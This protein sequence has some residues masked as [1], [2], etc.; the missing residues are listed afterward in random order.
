[1]DKDVPNTKVWVEFGQPG[2]ELLAVVSV[3]G[4]AWSFSRLSHQ[5]SLLESERLPVLAAAV[6]LVFG[7]WGQLWHALVETQWATA[8]AQ[9]R[10]WQRELPL[11][12]WPYLEPGTP[13]A[14]LH[15]TLSQA[16]A[17]WQDVGH[18]SLEL[19]LRS[20]LLA[21]T[22]TLLLSLVLGRIAIVCSL[23]FCAWA[24]LAALWHE[25]QG[26]V[27]ALWIGWA[28]VGLP[29]L[30]G[31]ML[32]LEAAAGA[33]AV[34]G[35]PAVGGVGTTAPEAKLATAMLSA[36]VL[37]LL[38]ALYLQPSVMALLGPIVAAIYLILQG[39]AF[40]AGV[41]LLLAFPGLRLILHQP[42]EDAYRRAVIPWLLIMLIIIAGSLYL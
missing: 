14:A 29:W 20:A 27:S 40:I 1:M 25:G 13:G 31:A 3:I 21:L 17:W 39:R 28:R 22:V 41:V 32:V 2:Y 12:R 18:K 4:A 37:T 8:L 6:A 33:P 15:R 11:A 9:W 38:F 10:G 23:L 34:V 7:G 26:H 5:V 30:L 19:P 36:L 24:E 42:S 16:R 35:V